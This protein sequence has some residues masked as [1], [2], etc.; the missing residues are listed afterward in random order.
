MAYSAT[1]YHDFSY[2]HRVVGQGGKCE[3]LHGHNGRV[4]FTCIAQEG[5]DN[6]GRVID[7]GVIKD[8]LCVWVEANWDHKFLVWENDPMAQ[9][10][11]STDPTVVILP[12]NPTAENLAQYLVDIISPS[13][14]DGTG[15]VLSSVTFDETRK[16]SASYSRNSA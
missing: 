16:C 8:L 6:V 14:L 13:L 12:F 9:G 3:N 1:R 11:Q 2:G 4:H 15:V 5:L 10:L 7:F